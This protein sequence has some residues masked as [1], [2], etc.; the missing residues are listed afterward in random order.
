MRA[1][2]CAPWKPGYFA[3]PLGDRISLLRRAG[4]LET[5]TPPWLR[6][7]ILTPLPIQMR[8]GTLIEYRLRLHGIPFRWQSEIT[9]WEPPQRFVDEQRRGPYR[10]WIH[11]HTFTERD[12]GSEVRDFV[13]YSVLGG[14]LV[15]FLF[16]QHDVRRI[17]NTARGSC[18]RSSP[19]KACSRGA[20]SNG[21]I[22]EA[23]GI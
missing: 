4:N 17:L 18:V 11:E 19:E 1:G 2:L 16:V 14:C 13:R 22:S 15:D 8:R 23:A 10:Q 9:A 5:L 12:A 20:D 21:A 7:E 6:F 3:A